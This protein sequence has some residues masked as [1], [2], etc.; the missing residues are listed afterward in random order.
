MSAEGSWE[1]VSGEEQP[2]ETRLQLPTGSIYGYEQVL[3]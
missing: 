1:G 3:A 2:W